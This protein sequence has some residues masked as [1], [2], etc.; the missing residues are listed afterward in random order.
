MQDWSN[1][2][3]EAAQGRIDNPVIRHLYTYWTGKRA[4]PGTW[5]D[6]RAIDPAEIDPAALPYVVLTDIKDGPRIRF[7]LVGTDVARGV[8]PTWQY[9]DEASPDG[10]YRTHICRLYIL[11]V[12]ENGP[13]YTVCDYLA[14][15]GEVERVTHRIFLPLAAYGRDLAMLF[16]GQLTEKAHK[17]DQSLWQVRPDQISERLIAR[18]P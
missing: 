5:P 11:P 3:P 17:Q 6:R 14:P 12:L 18:L 16:V 7:R 1:R 2:S 15:D 9:L 13:F 10:A 8:D 4:Q